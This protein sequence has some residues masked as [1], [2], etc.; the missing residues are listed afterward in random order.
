GSPFWIADF[1]SR[2]EGEGSAQAQLVAVLESILFLI[3]VNLDGMRAHGLPLEQLLA[4]GGLAGSDF[5]CQSLA[6]LTGLPVTR[7]EEREATARGLAFLAAGQPQDW[8]APPAQVFQPRLNSAL[9]ERFFAWLKL[10]KQARPV[11]PESP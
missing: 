7:Y 5:V 8:P 1:P 11:S 9:R 3:R 10:M 4:T 2:F 6:D